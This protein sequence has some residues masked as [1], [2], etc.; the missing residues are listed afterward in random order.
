[1][2]TPLY[3]VFSDHKSVSS[4]LSFLILRKQLNALVKYES[5][6]SRYVAVLCSIDTSTSL[7][8]ASNNA[9]GIFQW[10]AKSLVPYSE[11]DK[12]W[13]IRNKTY[14]PFRSFIS[15]ITG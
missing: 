11:L 2:S 15:L 4:L 9:R 1:M 6:Q 13:I 7:L 12:G 3:F 10:R 5:N 8:G 14:I